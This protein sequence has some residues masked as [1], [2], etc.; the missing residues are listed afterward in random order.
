MDLFVPFRFLCANVNSSVFLISNFTCSLLAYRKATDL[1]IRLI[2]IICRNCL[3]APGV[4]L[5]VLSEF[6]LR[7][8]C[9]LQT[10]TTLISSFSISVSYISFSCL[11]ALAKTSGM[12]LKSSAGRGHPC[13]VS[14]LSGKVSGFSPLSVMIAI[15]GCL[16]IFFIDLRKFFSIP[17]L[18]K[19]LI[20][21]RYLIFPN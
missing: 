12:M 20:M 18:L 7:W 16:W 9:H 5:S 13:P 10:K 3:L 2:P 8:S 17:G 19:L 21:N 4:S 15:I 6:L 14:N 1:Y 11:T